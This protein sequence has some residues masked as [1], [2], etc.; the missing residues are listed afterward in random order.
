MV[1]QITKFQNLLEE[2]F[3]ISPN[4]PKSCAVLRIKFLSA[5]CLESNNYTRILFHYTDSRN[6]YFVGIHIWPV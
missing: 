2:M 6:T 5:C 3:R 4:I 1:L